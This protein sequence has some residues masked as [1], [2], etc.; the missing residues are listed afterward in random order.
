MHLLVG[1]DLSE[2]ARAALR[3]GARQLDHV[4]RT[5]PTPE[6]TV[7]HAVESR[8]PEVLRTDRRLEEDEELQQIRDAVEEWVAEAID[9]GDAPVEIAVERGD[10]RARLVEAVEA[11]D[12]DWLALGM[13]GRG[14]L[15]RL[16]AGS[17]CGALAHGPPTRLAICHPDRPALERG[18]ALV[19]GVDFTEASAAGLEMAADLTRQIDGELHVVHVVEPPTYEAYP[20]DSFGESDVRNMQDLVDHMSDEL[21]S[22]LEDHDDLLEGIEWTRHVVSGHPVE[23]LNWF[24]TEKVDAQGIAVGTAGRSAL[25]DF[26]T[27]STSRGLVRHMER[28]VYLAPSPA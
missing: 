19:A 8:Y 13:T 5:G 14:A 22:F 28:S 12:S 27:G 15:E 1:T 10:T 2:G 20:Y 11:R 16:V 24:A 18:D 7:L 25:A 4:R 9:P 17:T 23:H 6:L 3:W 21:Q 26:V